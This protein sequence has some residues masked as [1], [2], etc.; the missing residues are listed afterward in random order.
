MTHR[1]TEFEGL[2]GA[3]AWWVVAT[4]LLYNSGLGT[5]AGVN[6]ILKALRKGSSAVDVF[7]ILSGFVIFFLLEDRKEK[8]N[9]FLLRRFFRIYPVYI[10]C[11]AVSVLIS[12]IV[13]QN[14]E[15]LAWTREITDY[16]A[17]IRGERLYLLK[18]ALA[19]A[20]ML[21][22]IFPDE[23]LPNSTNAFL[24]PAWS[25][26][27]EWQFYLI[28]P[29]IIILL[30]R[31]WLFFP[32]SF[33]VIMLFNRF[34]GISGHYPNPAFLP[35]K[36]NLFWLGGVSF[37][38]FRFSQQNRERFHSRRWTY[39]AASLIVLIIIFINDHALLIPLAVWAAVFGTV[40]VKYNSGSGIYGRFAAGILNN[41]YLRKLGD[42]SYSTYL[43]HLPVIYLCQWFILQMF[44]E[45]GKQVMLTMLTLLSVPVTIIVSL[46]LNKTIEKPFI[47]LGHGFARG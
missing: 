19:H 29:L 27:L 16:L 25:T 14:M 20:A 30:K 11:F 4:H 45:A 28:A 3:L 12:G 5:D 17:R 15:S 6:I 44:P 13:V 22:G 8:Y 46:V 10:V 35:L 33:A 24:S 9:V 39:L 31:S 2:R 1:I 47:D 26:S 32:A 34:A 40:M 43:C 38:L 42:V 36:A 23:L 21:H 7:I 41:K 18:H 37:Y